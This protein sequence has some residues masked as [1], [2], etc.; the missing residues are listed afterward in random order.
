M[1]RTRI[2]RDDPMLEHPFSRARKGENKSSLLWIT[3]SDTK[4]ANI[5]GDHFNDSELLKDFEC[6]SD[7]DRIPFEQD[8][9]G[10]LQINAF[11]KD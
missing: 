4:E 3:S 5:P 7:E 10:L 8:A 2:E 11:L 1:I 9:A 6:L